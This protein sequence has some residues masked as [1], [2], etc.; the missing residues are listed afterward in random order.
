MSPALAGK[1]LTTALPGKP[2][3]RGFEDLILLMAILPK[4]IYIL[5]VIP[6][7]TPKEY[8]QKLVKFML[9]LILKCLQKCKKSRIGKTILKKKKKVEGLTLPAIKFYCKIRVIRTV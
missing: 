1:F 9:I 2:C 7:K 4:L 6:V 5:N 3:V 8:L